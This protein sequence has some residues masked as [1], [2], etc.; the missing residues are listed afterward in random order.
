MKRLTAVYCAAFLFHL[1]T[2]GPWV[3]SEKCSLS[4][5]VDFNQTYILVSFGLHLPISLVSH[6]RIPWRQGRAPLPLGPNSFIFMQF[7]AQNLQNNRLALWE[8]AP[9]PLRKILNPPLF[10]LVINSNVTWK[11]EVFYLIVLMISMNN[12][13]TVSKCLDL[14]PWLLM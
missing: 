11:S 10:L 6:E 8:F 4:L 1:G 2:R 13:S 14:K 9:P 5:I 3:T 7:L 12:L